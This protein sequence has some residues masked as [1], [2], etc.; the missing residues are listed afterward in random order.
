M[1]WLRTSI[2]MLALPLMLTSA[3]A[4]TTSPPSDFAGVT[5]GT[6]LH[7]LKQRHPEVARNPDSDRQFQVYQTL[8]LK[9]L[10]AKSPVA[11]SI[12]KGR[13]VGGQVMLDSNNAQ[14]WYDSMVNKYGKPDNC[15]YCNDPELVIANWMWGN[16]VRLHIGGEM[17]TLLTEEGATQ[18]QAWLGRDSATADKGDEDSDVGEVTHAHV[19]HAKAT[20]RK[21]VAKAVA[22]PNPP[23]PTKWD[24]YYANAKA[25]FGRIMGWSK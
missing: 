4:A 8:A 15:T 2:A 23:P 1:R 5:L 14:Q 12:Y 18:R 24:A 25:R 10:D 3:R 20:S 7:D 19:T 6:S 22:T 21:K 13:V 9:G 11:F 16:G 17:L